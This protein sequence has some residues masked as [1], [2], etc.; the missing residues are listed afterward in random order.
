MHRLLAPIALFSILAGCA[1]APEQSPFIREQLADVRARLYAYSGL[2]RAQLATSAKALMIDPALVAAA[3]AHS[4]ALAKQKRFD[5]GIPDYNTAMQHLLTNDKFQ[6]YVGENIAMQYFN[7]S[8]GIDAESV[9][10][11]FMDIWTKSEAHKRNIVFPG[12]ERTGIGLAINGNQIYAAQLFATD[13]GLPP[14]R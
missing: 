9:A 1:T 8:Q 5:V 2:E 3:Q 7:P 13:L 14:R 12:F 11:I 4:E 10:R 6:G